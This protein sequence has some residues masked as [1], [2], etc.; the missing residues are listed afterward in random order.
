MSESHSQSENS[1]LSQA[2][3]SQ[4]PA[5]QGSSQ[6]TLVRTARAPGQSGVTSQSLDTYYFQLTPAAEDSAGNTTDHENSPN[7]PNSQ[8]SD[9]SVAT[10]IIDEIIP[11]G[12][13]SAA[14]SSSSHA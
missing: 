11:V 2:L 14:S 13:I 6:S 7:F 8:N 10:I 1:Q 4:Q 9:D 5:T 3:L 12:E